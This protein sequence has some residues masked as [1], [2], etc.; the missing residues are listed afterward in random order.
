[1]RPRA[2]QPV[3]VL[4]LRDLG[5]GPSTAV[6]LEETLGIHRRNIREYLAMLSA[7]KR[8]HIGDWIQRTGPALPVWYLGEGRNRPRPKTIYRRTICT[9]Q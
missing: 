5:F 8:I 2:E 3:V 1:M 7:Q 9:K 6:E 4:I